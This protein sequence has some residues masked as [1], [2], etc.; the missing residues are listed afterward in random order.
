[1]PDKQAARLWV[2]RCDVYCTILIFRDY[3]LEFSERQLNALARRQ[4]R[5]QRTSHD[6]YLKR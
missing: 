5:R 4:C 2:G 6:M 1:M 3:S